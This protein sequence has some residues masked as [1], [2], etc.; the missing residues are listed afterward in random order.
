VLCILEQIASKLLHFIF[1]VAGFILT[2]MVVLSQLA[3]L[4]VYKL[5]APNLARSQFNKY[6][7]QEQILPSV[8]TCSQRQ[9]NMHLY[10][11]SSSR[12]IS[13]SIENSRFCSV[14]GVLRE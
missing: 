4:G 6:G 2:M 7:D 9:A 8:F 11:S 12:V 14:K 10:I 5:Y 13:L 1:G 3:C